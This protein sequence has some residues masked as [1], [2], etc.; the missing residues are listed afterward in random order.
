MAQSAC[1]CLAPPRRVD[2]GSAGLANGLP[3]KVLLLAQFYP[4][5]VG[6]EERHVRNLARALAGRGHEV[7]VAT[8]DPGSGGAP[9]DAG[10]DH[11]AGVT[12]HVLDS[13]GGRAP[14]LYR[15]ADRPPA[16]PVPDPLTARGLA[17][18]AASV[19]PDVVHA[20]NWIVNSWLAVPDAHRLPLML[21]LH[22]YGH[23]CATKRFMHLGHPCS[24]PSPAKCLPCS[25]DHY[26]LPGPAV[27]AG[28][29]G[30]LPVRWRAVDLFAP[31]STYVAH[32]NQ[33]DQH[34]VPWRVVPNF[35]P[36]ELT[37]I[38]VAERDPALP[39]GRYY[40][41]AGDLMAQKGVH[42]LLRA[43]QRLSS[44]RP[45][46][47]PD[48]VLVGR[49]DGTLPDPLPDGVH[50]HHG[51]AHE[52]VLSGFQH[53]VAATLPSEWPDPC[54]TTVLE[55]MAVGAPLVTTQQG[56]IADMVTGGE[57]ALVVPPGDQAALTRALSRVADD[58]ALRHRLVV[59]AS[60][61]VTG[62]LQSSVA[63]Q[64]EGIY[65]G[66]VRASA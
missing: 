55:A 2:T 36:D 14:V 63:E 5:V 4:P 27:W 20:H 56:G 50:V 33:L 8:L 65:A 19:R 13:V 38:P 6:G 35:V 44:D 51:W 21:S 1:A 3:V 52:R 46:G 10:P 53:A 9:P 54:P 62:F 26:G 25:R 39:P 7:H 22:D 11:D 49:S 64:L 45:G 18:L 34:A 40:F 43:W 17:R 57:S 12:V 31:V 30:G 37:R 15:S 47:R 61:S 60:G 32:A 24:G 41:Y 48:L 23:V 29:R 16:L 42:T 59:G 28:L 58:A 66:V